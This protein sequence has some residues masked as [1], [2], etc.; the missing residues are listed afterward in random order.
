MGVDCFLSNSSLGLDLTAPGLQRL[1]DHRGTDRP[2]GLFLYFQISGSHSSLYMVLTL[3]P[4]AVE[5]PKPGQTRDM[6]NAINLERGHCSGMPV[7]SPQSPVAQSAM[8]PYSTVTKDWQLF[9][10]RSRSTAEYLKSHGRDFPVQNCLDCG[11]SGPAS[12]AF[13]ALSPA[14]MAGG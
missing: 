2:D 8:H 9:C 11:H 13:C 14:K 7:P 5:W 12:P 1:L 3:A 6:P 10:Q 4:A